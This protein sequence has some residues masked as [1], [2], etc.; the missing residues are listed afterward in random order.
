MKKIKST[1]FYMI[2]FNDIVKK[3]FTDKKKLILI[4]TFS[5]YFAGTQIAKSYLTGKIVD[6]Q[7]P[8]Y[9]FF[10]IAIIISGFITNYYLD[11]YVN[12]LSL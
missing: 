6:L 2:C 3:L 10:Y 7:K 11:I 5:L 12:K 4:F 9:L 1:L 8:K